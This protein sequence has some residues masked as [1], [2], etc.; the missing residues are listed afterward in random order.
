MQSFPQPLTAKEEE[1][2]IRRHENGDKEARKIL[3]ERNLRLVAYLVK[4]YSNLDH[5][6]EDL[7]SIG[8]IGLIKAVDSYNH[9]KGVRLAT[10]ASRCI[11]NELLMTFRSSKKQAKEVYL[12][13]PISGGDGDGNTINLLDLLETVDEDIAERMETEE[14]VKKLYRYVETALT[15]REKEII[16]LRYGLPRT[17]NLKEKKEVTQREIAAKYG[18]SRSYVSRIEKKALEKLRNAYEREVHNQ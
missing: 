15:D 2:Y 16:R 17:Q 9:T 4:K 3:I 11:D 14:N 12:Y 18:I 13:E 5:S 8:T 7:I 10:Y 1:E 6:Q